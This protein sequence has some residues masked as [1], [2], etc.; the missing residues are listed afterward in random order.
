MTFVNEVNKYPGLLDIMLEIEGVVKQRSSHASGV[1]MNDEN[2]YEFLAYMKTPEGEIITQFDLHYSEKLGATKYD[3]LVTAVQDKI[4]ECIHL[5][6]K[7][8]KIDVSL[9]LREVY[10]KYL[11]PDVLDFEDEEVWKHI[12]E[13]NILDLFQF[14]SQVGSQGILKVQP[15]NIHELTDTNGL[16]RLMT[17]EKG[18]ETPL[19]RYVRMKNDISLWYQE[20]NECGLTKEEQ[21]ALEPYYLKSYGTPP[22]QEQLMLY[23]M[24]KN[25]CGF[26]LADSN[27]ARKIIAKKKMD[28]IPKLKEK[29]YHMAKSPALGDYIW[30]H[31]VTLQ[32][33]YAFSVIH[34]LAYSFIGYQTAYLATKW[35]PIYWNTACL[36]VNSGSLADSDK[37][38]DYAKI[39]KAIGD[40]KNRNVNVSL[41]DI[42]KSQY[43][44]EPNEKENTILYGLKALSNINAEMIEQIQQ[45]RPYKSIKDFMNRCPLRKTAMI[46]LIKGGAFDNLPIQTDFESRAHPRILTMIYYI[47]QVCEPKKRL[48]MQNFNGLVQKNLIPKELNNYIKIFYFNKELKS[49]KIKDK[50]EIKEEYVDYF[51][52][53]FDNIAGYIT[54]TDNQSILIEQKIWDKTYKTEMETP[55]RYILEHQKELL[56][57]FNNILFNEMWNKY[58]KGNLST[59]EMD[60]VCFYYSPHEL[61]DIHYNLYGLQNFD[62]MPRE[63]RVERTWKRKGIELPIYALTRIIGTVIAKDDAHSNIYLLTPEMRVITVK[64]NRDQYAM[65]KKQISEKQIDGTKKVMEKSWFTRGTKLMLTGFRRED[66]F[67]IKTYKNTATHSIYKIVNINSEKGEMELIHER[68][69]PTQED[70]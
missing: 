39:A 54:N 57:K 63:P 66:T 56:T 10:N 23:L 17:N 52:S 3:Y 59:W 19:D 11:H 12:K 41:I 70:E 4:T 58:A 62:L 36:I 34:A 37:S 15:N 24:D 31:G 38:A 42:N 46:N 48:T 60:S 21:K 53:T 20:M 22:S 67:V 68:Y 64:F 30:H 49:H 26:S 16:I 69:S 7:Y 6:Q 45:G 33:G 2:P 14:D 51:L 55:K 32:L 28:Q 47:S 9:S 50:Y 8:N 1:I 27:N 65:Y 35:N 5:L 25:I 29:V 13:N 40:I 18:E 44:F 43:S 61:K